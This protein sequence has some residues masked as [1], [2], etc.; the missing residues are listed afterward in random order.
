MNVYD[1]FFQDSA[2]LDKD[3]VLGSKESISFKSLNE[4]SLNLASWLNKTI[5]EGK[6]IL[7]LYP[8]SV[9]SII[10]YLAIIKSGNIC[11]PLVSEIEKSNL[12]YIVNTTEASC[13]FV[14]AR[15]SSLIDYK[16][17]ILIDEKE[18]QILNDK[19]PVT[20]PF[21]A[22]F[23]EN[24]LAELIFTSGSTGEPK[25]VM[26]S[27]KNLKANTESIL[28]YLKLSA[29][30]TIMAVLPF[31]YCYGL[32]LLHTHLRVGGS[33]VLNNSFIFIGAVISDMIKYRCTGFAGVP[34]HFQILLRKTKSFKETTFPDLRYVT[35][36]GGKLHTSFI[37]EFIES[38]PEIQFY[39][40][41]GQT[42][43]T[44][45]LSF[46]PPDRLSDKLGSIGK[47]IPGVELKILNNT[48]KPVKPNEVGELLAKGDNV[49]LGYFK[50]KAAT[51]HT[52]KDGWLYTGDLAKKDEDGFIYLVGRMKEMIKV[53]GRRINPK[54]IEEVI[55]SIPEVIDC[56]V[57][58]IDDE[59]LGEAIKATVNIQKLSEN[60]L[61][62]KDI[63]EY[64][65]SKLSLFKV[66]KFIEF[67]ENMVL[68][69][70]GKKVLG[71]L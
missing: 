28:E 22:E 32:S 55:V 51:D 67:K 68:A 18:F 60:K 30:D 23:D 41:Y 6:N 70:T 13:F 46:L 45:R 21:K 65:A 57:E 4:R 63:Q 54:E 25:G 27:H 64:C 33:I 12:D 15:K 34:S 35:Q 20:I 49:M 38:F 2:K 66:P 11:V 9:N 3:F 43:A 37:S 36:A 7:L 14:P 50:D 69:A 19:K 56:S 8:N 40:M 1:Y 52:L 17:A 26:L 47:G 59:F 58:G 31:Y 16:G 39:V 29:N 48:G 5:G 10:A 71:K 53:G 42:E 44:A 24:R 62:D 61:T